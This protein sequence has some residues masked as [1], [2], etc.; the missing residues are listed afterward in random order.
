MKLLMLKGLPGSGKS[1]FSFEL[2]KSKGYKR[3][4]KDD[5]RSMIDGGVWTKAHE[6]EIISI[7]NILVDAWLHD[8]HDVVVDDTN[9]A[10]I[11][12]EVLRKYAEARGAEFEIKFIDTPLQECIARDAL[13]TGKAHV[14]KK[15]ITDM[16]IQYLRK[17]TPK[18]PHNP[19]LP[20]CYIFDIDGTL[21]K[22]TDRSPY[23]YSKVNTDIENR[24]V[25]RVFRMLRNSPFAKGGMMFIMSGRESACRYATLQWLQD[26][27]ILADE[28][29]MRDAGDKRQDSIIKKELYEKHIKG[30][31]NVMGVF[32]D[33]DQ[34]VELWRSLG[35]TC[36]Q[37]D[38]GNF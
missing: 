8:G 30:K 19:D 6:T 14:G 5:L 26:N 4:N 33:R 10:P 1:T 2:V 29:F 17:Q 20:N 11:H 23:D 31:Y 35:L 16:Y 24:D 3:V 21:A 36:F 7:R 28:V 37:V 13:R 38:Y 22:M 27:E 32:D 12:E 9:F 34:V 15:V 25:A 18:I